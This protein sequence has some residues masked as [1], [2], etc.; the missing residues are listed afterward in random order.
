MGRVE[1]IQA[2]IESL[3]QEEYVRLREWF[4]ERDWDAWDKE[5]E[6]DSRAGRLD[7]FVKEALDEKADGR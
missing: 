7:F 1:K 2:E 6:A 5:I 3:P 4:T